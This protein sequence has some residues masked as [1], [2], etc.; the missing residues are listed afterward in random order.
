[1]H[2]FILIQKYFVSFLKSIWFNNVLGFCSCLIH[3]FCFGLL[4]EQPLQELLWVFFIVFSY[5]TLPLE[6]VYV[7]FCVTVLWP[8][9][10]GLFSLL[11]VNW[12][13]YINLFMN[14]VFSLL[15]TRLK[16][17]FPFFSPSSLCFALGYCV[18]VSVHCSVTAGGHSCTHG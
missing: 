18:R 6:S 4:Q 8:L 12:W 10:F 16:M 13:F 3:H 15:I 17:S 14:D 2:L 11:T 1:M 7:K 9:F 5:L